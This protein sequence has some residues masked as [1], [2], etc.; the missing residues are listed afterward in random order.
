MWAWIHYLG[1]PRNAYRWCCRLQPIFA[2][3]AMLLLLIGSYNGLFLAPADYQQGDAFRIMYVHVPAA[4]LSTLVYSVMAV[5]AFIFLVWKIKVCDAMVKVSAPL[6]AVFTLIT[7]VAGSI[8]GKPTWG[9]WW[10]WDAR[11]TSELILL[12]IYL[13]IILLRQLAGTSSQAGRLCAIFVLIGAV[14]LPIIHY[15][16][17]WWHTLHQG[18][19]ILKWGTPSIAPSML[20]P[21]LILLFGFVFFYAWMLCLGLR[22]ELL[23]REAKSRWVKALLLEAK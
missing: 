11:L 15:S 8:W 14:N 20:Q 12:F 5:N 18:A 17:N 22:R 1:A 6:G 21:L 19:S 23:S 9:T 3:A 7:L 13:G 10:I 4:V 16:V 2:V